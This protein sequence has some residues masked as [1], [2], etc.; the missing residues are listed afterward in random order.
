MYIT[1]AITIRRHSLNFEVRTGRKL[2]RSTSIAR[3]HYVVLFSISLLIIREAL[4]GG[5]PRSSTLFA[6]AF[7]NILSVPFRN[8]FLPHATSTNASRQRTMAANS[9]ETEARILNYIKYL[10]RTN[11][12]ITGY[13]NKDELCRIIMLHPSIY[14]ERAIVLVCRVAY[15]VFLLQCILLFQECVSLLSTSLYLTSFSLFVR[16]FTFFP[17]TR[18]SYLFQ[19]LFSLSLL[20]YTSSLYYLFTLYFFAYPFNSFKLSLVSHFF[21]HVSC[22]VY[23]CICICVYVCMT[24]LTNAQVK[25]SGAHVMF[26]DAYV[27]YCPTTGCI[28]LNNRILKNVRFYCSTNNF[29]KL[30]CHL[31]FSLECIAVTAAE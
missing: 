2:L 7:K 25:W 12:Y 27:G 28:R 11:K 14:S 5:H 18:I 10:L 1:T 4:V 30:G 31:Q 24:S 21:E 23:V 20:H 9:N 19:Y 29:C 16:S 26:V 3:A 8:A 22:N 15:C 6:S 17:Y 13:D